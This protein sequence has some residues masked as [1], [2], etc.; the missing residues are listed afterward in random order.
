MLDFGYLNVYHFE[1]CLYKQ[2]QM[3]VKK[4]CTESGQIRGRETRAGESAP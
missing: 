3:L 1:L 2:S 4:L